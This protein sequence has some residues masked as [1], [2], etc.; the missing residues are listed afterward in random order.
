MHEA[1]TRNGAVES[2]VN[3]R[4]TVGQFLVPLLSH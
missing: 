2:V 3:D 1:D 4:M